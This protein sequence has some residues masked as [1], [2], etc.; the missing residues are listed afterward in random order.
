MELR[1]L[2]YFVAVAERRNFT[3]AAEDLHVAQPAISQQ[4]KSLEE[5]LEVTLLLRT[6]R[7]VRLTAAGEAFLQECRGILAHAESSRQV[8][9]RAARGEIGS[10]S[11][12]GFSSAVSGFL[13]GLILEYRRRFPGVRV[14]LF[15]MT[16][17]EQLQAFARGRIDV[18]FTRPLGSEHDGRFVQE[19][20]YRDCL[21]LAVPSGHRLARRGTA[22]LKDLASEEF[23]ILRRGE[24]PELVDS[25]TR[26]CAKAG[27]T[28][29]IAS[30]PPMMQ[31]VM[32][33]VAS[34]I[35]VSLVP[36]CVRNFHQDG[37]V[38]LK[39]SPA[40]PPID[41]VAIRP[42]GEPSPTVAAWM[43]LL[44][45]RTPGIRKMMEA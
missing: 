8:A 26:H 45:E 21:V 32:M 3:R 23:V 36:G 42:K 10:L 40:S 31:T 2:R 29:R 33:A 1:H 19:K 37:V 17:E 20:I 39:V 30:H 4:I 43:E 14:H 11:I 15:E 38:L 13:P 25:M 12:G 5:E 35:G 24:A 44:R 18:G 7:S 28:P 22:A 9:R 27:F 16:P 41:L 6:R 34:G